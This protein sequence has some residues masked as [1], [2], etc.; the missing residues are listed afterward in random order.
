MSVFTQTFFTFVGGHLM[1]FSFFTAWHGCYF[2]AWDLTLVMNDL[3][4]LKAGILCAGMI[5]VVFLNIFLAVFLALFLT[6]KL[7]KPLRNTLL[8]FIIESFTVS[9]K[10]STVF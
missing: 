10:A 1:S 9:I 5:M 3:A 6:I 8:P 4:G 7:P 2:L